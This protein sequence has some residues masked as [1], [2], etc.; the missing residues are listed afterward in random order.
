MHEEDEEIEDPEVDEQMDTGVRKTPQWHDEDDQD[1]YTTR[2][3]PV[4]KSFYDRHGFDER[5]GPPEEEEWEAIAKLCRDL[6]QHESIFSFVVPR[7]EKLSN[8]PRNTH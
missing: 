7:L 3:Q 8:H 6:A 2:D 4:A 1:E 5:D